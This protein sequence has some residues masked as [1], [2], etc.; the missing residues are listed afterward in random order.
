MD[1]SN[2]LYVKKVFD[3]MF[4]RCVI[5]FKKKLEYGIDNLVTWIVGVYNSSNKNNLFQIY[6]IWQ[7][8]T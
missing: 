1:K 4:L 7:L 5:N 3:K 2:N 8:L 6:Q